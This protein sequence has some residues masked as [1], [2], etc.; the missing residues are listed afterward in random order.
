VC[1]NGGVKPRHADLFAT[2]LDKATL[3]QYIDRFFMFYIRTAGRLQRTAV[4]MENMEGGLEYLKDVIIHDTLGIGA[5]LEAE[6]AAV[7]DTYECEWKKTIEDPDKVKR[8]RHFVN[9]DK[10]DSN[11]IFVHERGQIR[12]ATEAEKLLAPRA[13][14]G[15]NQLP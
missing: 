3:I 1:G 12:P 9:S 11:V 2:E 14:E 10:K 8:F 6:M 13:R 7:I 4:W 15:L 5:E